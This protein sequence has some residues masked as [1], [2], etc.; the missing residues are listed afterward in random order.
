MRRTVQI[1]RNKKNKNY[2][3]RFVQRRQRADRLRVPY[4]DCRRCRFV[5]RRRERVSTCLY[6]V[7]AAAVAT[8]AATS[9]CL[10][11][12]RRRVPTQRAFA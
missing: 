8:A 1:L 6:L 10:A 5:C 11:I 4:D 2:A 3:Q 12:R 9:A 7:A